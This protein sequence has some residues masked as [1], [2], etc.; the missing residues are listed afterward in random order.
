MTFA[1]SNTIHRAGE[2]GEGTPLVLVHAFPI[3]HHMWDECAAAI[4]RQG[5]AAGLPAFPIWAPD[6]P[7]AGDGPI[8]DDTQSGG[9]DPDGAYPHAMDLLADAYVAMLHD[10]GYDRAVWVG[11]SM[12]GYVVL[13][14]HRRHPDAIAGIALCDTKADADD[15]R[16]R[17]NRTAIADTCIRERTIDPVMHFAH[18]TDADSTFKRSDA[19]KALFARWIGEQRPDGVAWRQRMAAARPDLNAQLPLID[20][21]ATVLTGDLDPSSP[22]AVMHP[23]AAAMTAT[24]P[25]VVDIADCG[26]FSAVEHPDQ[27]AA[28]LVDLM[29]R[30]G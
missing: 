12:G 25:A 18:A 26:H 19:G 17:A 15:A 8:P 4:I 13:D 23:I 1:I 20:V 22:P 28:A 27:V 30:V 2:P 5:D 11:L 9:T 24:E 14:I 3:D 29:H 10:A 7:G 16:Q 6:M 21:P